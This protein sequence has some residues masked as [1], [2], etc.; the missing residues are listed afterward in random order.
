MYS[1]DYLRDVIQQ[2][3]TKQYKK[4]KR[5]IP[6]TLMKKVLNAA[7]IGF[8]STYISTKDFKDCPRQIFMEII[9]PLKGTLEKE[10]YL[11]EVDKRSAKI[12]LT[13]SWG[14]KGE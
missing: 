12:Y 6:T 2:Y 4:Y 5:K 11:C 3:N 13:V 10:G 7:K 9:K 14:N 1:V 8:Y